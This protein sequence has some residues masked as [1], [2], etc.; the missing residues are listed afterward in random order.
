[1]Y[2]RMWRGWRSCWVGRVR[3]DVGWGPR[4]P[5]SRAV[6]LNGAVRIGERLGLGYRRRQAKSL[7]YCCA[8]FFGA[9]WVD[10]SYRSAT[11]F[12]ILAASGAWGRSSRYLL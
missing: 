2:R 9:S 4:W 10:F 5:D 12:L 7:S 11:A 8:A 1:M 6:L 3:L